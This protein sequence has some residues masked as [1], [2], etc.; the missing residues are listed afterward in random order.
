MTFNNTG[1]KD[2]GLF[3]KVA[4]V[5]RLTMKLFGKHL[6]AFG[7]T[8]GQASVL[9]HLDLL[10]E[11]A[12]QRRIA[13]SMGIEPPTLVVMLKK[14]EQRELVVRKHCSA[15]RRNKGLFFT[16][17]GKELL[18]KIVAAHRATS[19]VIFDGLSAEELDRT[20]RLLE[21]LQGHRTP[22]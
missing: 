17:S 20:Q 14:M 16:H 10:G 7:I 21:G 2:Q 15:D 1:P 4:R 5:H 19:D 18:S 11:G 22:D 8:T 12:G 9:L 6:A 3:F 13:E